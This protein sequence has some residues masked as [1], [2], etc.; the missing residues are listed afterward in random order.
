M[1]QARKSLKQAARRA[2]SSEF[3]AVDFHRTSRRY[4]PK[5]KIPH[6]QICKN[7]DPISLREEVTGQLTRMD[8]N[9]TAKILT[10]GKPEG[11]E[12]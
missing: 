11:K 12:A 1:S 3:K 5:D 10:F 9:E 7:S 6:I 8:D 4:V 2:V